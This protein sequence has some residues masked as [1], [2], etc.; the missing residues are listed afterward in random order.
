MKMMVPGNL[1]DDSVG[2]KCIPK[3][4]KKEAVSK[5]PRKLRL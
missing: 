4:E 5:I 2:L 3:I 1:R